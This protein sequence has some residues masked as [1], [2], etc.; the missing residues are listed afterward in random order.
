MLIADKKLRVGEKQLNP[1][2][3]AAFGQR[4]TAIAFG[5]LE[6]ELSFTDIDQSLYRAQLDQLAQLLNYQGHR[7]GLFLDPTPAETDYMIMNKYFIRSSFTQ[8]STCWICAAVDKD[9]GA[10]VAVKKIVAVSS[11]TLR[12]ARREIDAMRRLLVEHAPVRK[13]SPSTLISIEPPLSNRFLS[14]RSQS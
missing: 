5:D 2:N 4:K 14:P 1:T 7:P 12:H 11:R 9:T 8:G 10:S 6:Y 3:V 13:T